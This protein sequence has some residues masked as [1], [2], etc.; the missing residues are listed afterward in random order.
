VRGRLT[1][2]AT[3]LATAAAPAAAYAT[4]FDVQAVDGTEADNYDNRWTPSTVNAVVGDT[5]TWRFDGTSMPHN[6]M[7]EGANWKFRS[8]GAAVA[9]PPA[10]FTFTAAGTYTF[11]C[12]VHPTTMRGTVSVRGKD[13]PDP[14]PPKPPPPPPPS[15]Q[16]F[17]NDS[18]APRLLEL[19][20]RT[21]PAVRNVKATGVRRGVRVRY[22]VSEE[23]RVTVTVRR[24][25][26]KVKARTVSVRRGKRQ[27]VVRGLQRG[28]YRVQVQARDLARNK[29]RVRTVT[30]RV[31]RA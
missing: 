15:E 16:A 18:A 24:G 22:S 4:T 6:V 21:R 5:V 25:S 20:D 30:V 13:A 28:K 8:G 3:L 23:S 26:R 17:P 7:S 14:G 31:K 10:S 9:P 27:L 1:L 2:A 12:Q 11:I 29:S 19:L